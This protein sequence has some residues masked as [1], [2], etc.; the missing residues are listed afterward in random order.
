MAVFVD[1]LYSDAPKN[2]SS[3]PW[4]WCQPDV[5][6]P[7]TWPG[8]EFH[9]RGLLPLIHSLA[10]AANCWLVDDL[11]MKPQ[12]VKDAASA[13]YCAFKWRDLSRLREVEFPKR[14]IIGTSPKLRLADMAIAARRRNIP[15]G[16]QGVKAGD[17]VE[18]LKLLMSV[19]SGCGGPHG[20]G[21]LFPFLTVL[22]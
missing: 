3:E 2:E 4:G 19:S 18:L 15:V 14:P 1:W 8:W 17:G 20:R 5:G 11:G 13:H 10:I 7:Y 6:N 12:Q 9:L 21:L 22:E 16:E